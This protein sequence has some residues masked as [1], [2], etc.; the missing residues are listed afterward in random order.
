MFSS[1]EWYESDRKTISLSSLRTAGLRGDSG[2]VIFTLPFPSLWRFPTM[3]QRGGC[4]GR[5]RSREARATVFLDAATATSFD[6]WKRKGLEDDW[7]WFDEGGVSTLV[8]DA[9]LITVMYLRTRVATG[10]YVFGFP[11]YFA[12]IITD[13]DLIDGSV[14]QS[15]MS[16]PPSLN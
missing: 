5:G 8:L 12:R 9:K 6:T 15:V 4:G 1:F 7:C 10:Y 3:T 13:F 16:Q 14:S 2:M 11:Y